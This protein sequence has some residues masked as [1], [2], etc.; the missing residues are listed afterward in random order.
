[1]VCGGKVLLHVHL[2]HLAHLAHVP[3][4]RVH[5]AHVHA[6]EACVKQK[7]RAGST[8]QIVLCA[9]CDAQVLSLLPHSQVLRNDF[10]EMRWKCVGGEDVLLAKLR[11]ARRM[12]VRKDVA[13][14][15][16][17]KLTPQLFQRKVH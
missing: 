7:T 17:S 8:G 2:A 3:L 16:K 13:G 14:A 6:A 15:W 10:M 9:A 4:A 1:M 11:T 12:H 5:T